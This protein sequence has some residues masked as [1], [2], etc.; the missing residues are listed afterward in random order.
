MPGW[1][2]I[3]GTVATVSDP[4]EI[5]NVLGVDGVR[6]M[7]EDSE[8]VPVK[9]YFG[10]PSCVPATNF[11]MSGAAIGPEQVEYLLKMKEIRYLA[12]VMNFPGVINGEPNIIEKISIAK[13]YL[14]LIDGHAPGLRGKD[15]E[16]YVKSGISTD[17]ECFTRDE[18]L[19]KIQMGMKILIREGSAA[20][21][22]EELIPIVEEHY[23]SCMFCSD[24]R[25]PDDLLKGHINDLVK[26]AL[27]HG[28][29]LMKVL[30]VACV[31]PVLH[32]G[33]DVG[34]LRKG[35]NAD[36]IVIDNTKDFKVLKT[37]T[38]GQIVAE[39]LR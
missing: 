1:Q 35:D 25:H 22:F 36:F 19:E 24:D 34:L 32:Y 15:I 30:S 18:A 28:I 11:E 39:A 27:D 7:I 12:E 16:K 20:K 3:H 21:N 38:N 10:A 31:N 33:L 37:C 29:D 4:H 9:F 14:K 26:R 23:K 5:A 13:K 2:Q 6:Y 17:H 8:A